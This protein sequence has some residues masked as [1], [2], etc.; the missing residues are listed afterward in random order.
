MACKAHLIFGGYIKD[1]IKESYF[2]LKFTFSFLNEAVLKFFLLQF[3][4]ISI[5]FRVFD[6]LHRFYHKKLKWV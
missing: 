3:S 1:K 5:V 6:S 2:Y 4:D